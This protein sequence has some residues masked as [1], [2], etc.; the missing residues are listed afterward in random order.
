VYAFAYTSADRSTCSVPLNSHTS[1]DLRAIVARRGDGTP[2]AFMK[3]TEASMTRLVLTAILT[4]A[5][6][7]SALAQDS[8]PA[9]FFIERI[10]VR[11]NQRVSPKLII[12]ESLLREGSEYSEAD[13][14]AASSRLARLPFLLSADFALEKGSDRGRHVLVISVTETKPF[15]FLVDAR[16]TM[17]DDSRR[18]VDYDVDFGTESKDAA[19]G[20][21]WFVGGRGIVHVGVSARR[22]RQAFTTDY[23]AFAVGYT[24]YDLLGT[25][26]FATLNIRLPFDSPAEGRISPQ[27]VVGVPLTTN[28]TLTLDYE[29]T[30]S[31]R[32]TGRVAETASNGKTAGRR[33]PPP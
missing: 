1:N 6:A 16:P 13:L 26:A 2:H 8:A 28:Q 3:R 24:Q 25:R 11:N 29:D 15:F 9:R 21:R 23:S 17:W 18:T 14:S 30:F 27:L 10:E 12:S 19:L 20:F 33:I 5:L 4:A 32:N 7:V 22:D 31:G